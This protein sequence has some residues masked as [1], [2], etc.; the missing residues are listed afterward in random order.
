MFYKKRME[1]RNQDWAIIRIDS[2][3]LLHKLNTEFYRTNAANSIYYNDNRLHNTNDD[4]EDMFY[5]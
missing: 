3:L 4:L 2:E 5:D 1:D